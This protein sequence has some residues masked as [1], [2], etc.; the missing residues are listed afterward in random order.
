LQNKY[1][2]M[3]GYMKL[4]GVH[5]C[6]KLR[7]L[8][9]PRQVRSLSSAAEPEATFTEKTPITI[10]L[11]KLRHAH[12]KAESASKA[13]RSDATEGGPREHGLVRKAAARSRVDVNYD[14]SSDPSLRHIYQDFNGNLLLEKFLEDLD[15]L[16]GN[17]AFFHCDDGVP[18][19]SPLA[20]VTASVEEIQVF[21]NISA[22]EDIVLSGQV[23][24]VGSSSL[25]VLVEAHQY[26]AGAAKP[27]SPTLLDPSAAGTR[28]LS[29]VFTYVARSRETGKAAQVNPL[30][31]EGMTEHE[32]LFHR[33][34]AEA[35]AARKAQQQGQG[36]AAA[37][38][39]EDT[40][41][42]QLM[43]GLVDRGKAM[44]DMP[45]LV[46]RGVL[47]GSTALENTFVCQPQ[48]TN[49][50]GNVFGGYLLHEALTLAQASM[51]MFS[52]QLGS[53]TRVH[54]I[55]FRWPVHIGDLIR[56]RSRVSYVTDE[57]PRRAVCDITCHVV[58]PEQARSTLSSRFSFVFSLGGGGAA[59]AR[60]Q[61]LPA[62][63]EE[64]AALLTAACT[65]LGR[66]TE[67]VADEY[68]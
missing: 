45:A 1:L 29:S 23:A 48:K 32:A 11:W 62:T 7:P 50:A 16:A 57:W 4:F 41:T 25:E 42:K 58:K 40:A 15:A 18:A 52:G 49:T 54:R 60:K 65:V 14:L 10:Q 39:E 36:P 5:R 20:L 53:L 3:K 51:Y 68:R 35:A 31:G 28:V 67:E 24:W 44:V 2:D 59:G 19:S 17:V 6:L 64:A 63:R 21:R 27:A 38:E 13:R 22:R 46:S 34:R 8:F 55:S 61:V 56:L 43:V 30:C 66:S 47:M 26:A 9:T 12:H 37:A 33:R